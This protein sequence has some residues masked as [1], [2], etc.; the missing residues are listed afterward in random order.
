[1]KAKKTKDAGRM[2]T[3]PGNTEYAVSRKSKSSMNEGIKGTL[4]SFDPTFPSV[5]ST[6]SKIPGTSNSQV[7]ETP[8]NI[9]N[10]VRKG[11]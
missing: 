2:G 9:G 4:E 7:V 6:Y 8:V 10:R 11:Y 3:L 5:G 1:M